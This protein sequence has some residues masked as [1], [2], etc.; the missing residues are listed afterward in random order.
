MSF[1]DTALIIP[2]F[3]E[4][5]NIQQLLMHLMQQ[6]P[7]VNIIVSD[8][9]S[10]DGTREIIN[11]ISGCIL[12]DRGDE[13]VHGLTV[14]VLDAVKL[15]QTDYCVVMDGDGQHP[16][17]KVGEIIEKLRGGADVVVGSR[18]K[19]PNWRLDRRI[20]SMGA[21]FLGRLALFVRGAPRCSD[22]M[23]GFFGVK[24]EL[25]AGYIE[26]DYDA[27]VLEGYKVLFD[28]LKLLPGNTVID[29]VGY[30][31]G[32]RGG[33]ESKIGWKHIRLYFWSLF[34]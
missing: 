29:T 14:S 28:L 32:E 23:S 31:F 2:T 7:S 21:T 4:G 1:Y 18:D 30:D 33:G 5:K 17:E 22:V 16:P 27:F 34:K 26:S 3:N 25:M 24:R 8:D 15:A 19:I 11:N 12:L 6:Y 9:G 20:M 10:T 13:P